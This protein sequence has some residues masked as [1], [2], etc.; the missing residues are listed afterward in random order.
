MRV[1]A[2]RR[3]MAQKATTLGKYAAEIGNAA[4]L[5]DSRARMTSEKALSDYSR[6]ATGSVHK[7]LGG[8]G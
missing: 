2:V 1:I 5:G 7:S 8:C 3:T 4:A 6:S